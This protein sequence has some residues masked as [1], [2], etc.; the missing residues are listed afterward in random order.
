MGVGVKMPVKGFY[1]LLY[2]PPFFIYNIKSIV[3]NSI[4]KE[5]LDLQGIVSFI[6]I[7]IC[8]INNCQILCTKKG[9]G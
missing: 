7:K 4:Y 5:I 1:C 9:L 3:N 6:P 2:Y 8:V